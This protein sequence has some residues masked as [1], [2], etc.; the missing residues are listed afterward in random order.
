MDRKTP[1]TGL[2]SSQHTSAGTSYQV[3]YAKSGIPRPRDSRVFIGHLQATHGRRMPAQQVN[4]SPARRNPLACVR[5]FI[6][7]AIIR[8]DGFPRISLPSSHVPHSNFPVTATAH[9]NIVPWNHSPNAHNVSLQGLLVV[10]VSIVN[11]DLRII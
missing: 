3:P 4:S 10:P 2:M 9:K 8:Y 1:N 7:G 5:L 6:P 11:M